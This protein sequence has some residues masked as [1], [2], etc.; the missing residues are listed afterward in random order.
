MVD[1]VLW[2]PGTALGL[3]TLTFWLPEP[4][5][6]VRVEVGWL[7]ETPTGYT[8]M[9]WLPEPVE[10]DVLPPLPWTIV[11]PTL[12]DFVEMSVLKIRSKF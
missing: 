1:V 11:P 4:A 9:L 10:M 6:V 3:R 2:Y 8:E 7:S 5:F 12:P